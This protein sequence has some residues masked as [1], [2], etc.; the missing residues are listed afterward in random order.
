MLLGQYI[1]EPEFQQAIGVRMMN[2]IVDILEFHILV[3]I[4]R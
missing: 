1:V 3:F 2:N 4:P